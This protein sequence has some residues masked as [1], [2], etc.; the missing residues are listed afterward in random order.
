MKT[1]KTP[2][3]QFIVVTL[4]TCASLQATAVNDSTN[5]VTVALPGLRSNVVYPPMLTGH[6]GHTIGYIQRFSVNRREYLL[7]MF[8]K[9][10]K[11]F[12]KITAIFNKYDLPQEYKVLIAL[13][14]G[15]NANAVSPAGAV[16][17]WQIM[18]PVAREYGLKIAERQ[19]RSKKTGKR[20]KAITDERKNFNKSTYAA[21]RYLRDRAKNLNNDCLLIVASYNWGVGNVWNAME[22]SHKA[23]PTFWDIQKYVP[24]ETKAYVMNFIA[25]NVIFHN[26]EKFA[27]NQLNFQDTDDNDEPESDECSAL[28][29]PLP[30][31]Q[32]YF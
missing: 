14:S 3:T 4:F 19:A 27:K 25:L 23:N 13:E 32:S 16:G 6:E 24:A 20:K 11:F 8:N 9:G 17:Y 18:E 5:N 7:R 21:A 29:G 15:F 28:I 2:I 1:L 26:Y 22:R 10:K 30:H 31:I 12:P